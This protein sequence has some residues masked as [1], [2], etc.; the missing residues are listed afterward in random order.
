MENGKEK[1]RRYIN[2]LTDFGF[3]KVFGDEEIMRE[4][5]NDLIEPESPI[6]QVTFIDKEMQPETKYERGVIYDMRCRLSSGEEIIVEMQ[7]RGQDYFTDRI[8]YYLARAIA[9][10]GERGDSEWK[11]NLHPVYGVFFMNFHRDEKHPKQI[12][13]FAIAETETHQ[14]FSDKM[15]FWL[16]ELPDFKKM[17]EKNCK[18]FKD[19]WLYIITHM[20]TMKTQIPFQEQKP[21]FHKLENIADMAALTPEERDFYQ[22]SLDSFRTNMAVMEHERNEG[23]A[24]GRAKGLEEGRA[25]GRAEGLAEGRAE[26]LAEGE[27]AKAFAIA[28][29]LKQMGLHIDAII[30]ATGLDASEIEALL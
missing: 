23:R 15:Q 8:N 10:Q 3:K 7:N 24:E 14:R 1:T 22:I 20:E 9:T 18:S 2:P 5:L 26:G 17:K 30:Q 4:F 29:N 6:V 25:E 19:Y 27:K 13:N 11:F 16:I 12:S 28:V 21:I